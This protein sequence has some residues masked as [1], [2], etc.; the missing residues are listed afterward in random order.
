MTFVQHQRASAG[1]FEI[2]YVS[3]QFP[4]ASGIR[5][6]WLTATWDDLLWAA[7]TIGRPNTAHVFQHYEASLHEALFRISLVRMALEQHRYSR[8]LQRTAAFAALDPTEKG[9]VSYFLGM[10]VCKLFASHLLRTPWLLHLDLFRNQ[11]SAQ[12]LGGR[13]RPDLIGQDNRGAWH[14]FETKGRSSVP[15]ADDK[16]KAKAQ[17]RRLVTV[18][19]NRCALQIGSFTFFQSNE[20]NFYWRDPEPEDPEELT[21]LE[22]AV[23]DE[24]WRHYYQFAQA[25]SRDDGGAA[26]IGMGET[27]LSGGID[28]E[29]KIHGIVQELLSEQRWAEARVRARENEVLLRREGYQ[30]D[31]IRVMAGP[32]WSRSTHS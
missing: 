21:P 1:G 11:L 28:A 25:L 30:P 9:A 3:S 27:P 26:D 17:A 2:D 20:L 13:S 19:G 10:V 4:S 5:S 16:R 22:L 32:S 15:T 31:G 7:I 29:V 14:A 6:G 23:P 24:S 8:R 12:V 18:D